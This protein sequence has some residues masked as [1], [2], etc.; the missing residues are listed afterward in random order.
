MGPPIL[1]RSNL[2]TFSWVTKVQLH[3]SGQDICESWH[4]GNSAQRAIALWS[5][6]DE[7]SGLDKRHSWS[8]FGVWFWEIFVKVWRCEDVFLFCWGKHISV[9]ALR[10]NNFGGPFAI[11]SYSIEVSWNFLKICG[12]CVLPHGSESSG[13]VLA[14]TFF[15]L[16]EDQKNR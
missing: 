2:W 3:Q 6:L 12:Y 1:R 7:M 16:S 15:E 10:I 11:I 4:D 9:P 13:R 8:T 5:S 14:G